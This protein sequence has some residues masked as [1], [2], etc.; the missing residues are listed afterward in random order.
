MKRVEQPQEL[1]A[2]VQGKRAVV[3]V[4][5]TWCPY[6]R[7]YRPVFEKAT[8]GSDL[9][10]IEAVVDDEENPIWSDYQ[11]DIVP[12]VLFFEDGKVTRRLDGRPGVGLTKDEL[13]AALGQMD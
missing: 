2:A 6:C 3:L 1:E 9:E 4:H 12:T 10:V 5:A 11:V 7:A 13:V 8:Q